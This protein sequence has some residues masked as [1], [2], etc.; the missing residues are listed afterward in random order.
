MGFKLFI[1][2][3]RNIDIIGVELEI[4]FMSGIGLSTSFPWNCIFHPIPKSQ[5]GE[6]IHLTSGAAR[7]VLHMALSV[8][9]SFDVLR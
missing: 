3:V 1:G 9:D 5:K 2:S 4:D 8:F 7:K 6:M